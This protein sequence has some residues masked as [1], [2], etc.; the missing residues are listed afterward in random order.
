M[1]DWWVDQEWPLEIERRE[2]EKFN[3]ERGPPRP[4]IRKNREWVGHPAMGELKTHK[5]GRKIERIEFGWQF[6]S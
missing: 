2:V 4:L 3:D 5:A 1:K 6:L